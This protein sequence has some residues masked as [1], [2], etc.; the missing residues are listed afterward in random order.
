MASLRWKW[1]FVKLDYLFPFLLTLSTLIFFL[2]LSL[3]TTIAYFV[4]KK[5]PSS[6]VFL[7]CAIIHHKTPRRQVGLRNR[8]A[9]RILKIFPFILPHSYI[10]LRYK[11]GPLGKV[12]EGLPTRFKPFDDELLLL[13]KYMAFGVLKYVGDNLLQSNCIRNIVVHCFVKILNGPRCER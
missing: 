11:Q 9:T 8:P 13:D 3:C 12:Y 4:L 5:T 1:I 10:N 2:F 7:L 6:Y